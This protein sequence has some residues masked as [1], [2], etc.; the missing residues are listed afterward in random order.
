ALLFL[1]TML[2]KRK[3]PEEG[4][5]RIA[6]IFNGSPLF[7]GAAGS[8]PSN[9]RKWILDNDWLEA[10]VALP[11]Q[12]FY[13]TG[14]ATYVWV[15][16]NHK[17]PARTGRVQLIDARELWEPMPK[18]LGDKR[19]R[20]GEEHLNEVIRL[21]EGFEECER[22]KIRNSEFFMYRRITVE[23]PLRLRYAV[24]DKAIER[25]TASTAF[26]SLALPVA[27]AKDPEV[28]IAAG[29][30]TQ[31]ALVQ[32]LEAR[33]DFATTDREDVERFVKDVAQSID[34]PTSTLRKAVLGAVS[35]RDPQ[36]PIVR[37]RHGVSQP[38][39]EL[40]DYENVPFTESVAD[41]MAREVI[42]FAPDAWVDDSKEKVGS[43]IP[44]TRLFYRAEY[45]RPL[46]EIDAE[47]RELETEI[48]RLAEEVTTH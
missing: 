38:D 22:S 8:G 10:I 47:I 14:I 17:A 13:N 40:R 32:V 48:Q 44:F 45:P 6:I 27:N 42:P 15:L 25:L 23:R 4:G 3:P 19:R 20:L 28:A 9:I 18:S 36:A 33:R 5:S 1:Q 16:T 35:Q 31:R 12:L 46:E 34:R 2:A 26:Q 37:T 24:D 11:E 21:Y 7:S 30:R 43:E 41:H 29:E 39:P